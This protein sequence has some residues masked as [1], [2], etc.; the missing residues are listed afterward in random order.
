MVRGPCRCRNKASRDWYKYPI[1]AFGQTHF[2][3]GC[4]TCDS[5][6]Y[7]SVNQYEA[8]FGPLT[9]LGGPRRR[10]RALQVRQ[11]REARDA[12][13]VHRAREALQAHEARMA[14]ARAQV[15]NLVTDLQNAR[16]VVV[17]NL[18]DSASDHATHAHVAQADHVDPLDL[19]D[20]DDVPLVFTTTATAVV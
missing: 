12:L 8:Q 16:E 18:A 1:N 10:D 9:P 4:H 2:R 15:T 19:S 7:P 13:Q 11:A 5:H 20:T 17:R 3:T 6:K 14:L